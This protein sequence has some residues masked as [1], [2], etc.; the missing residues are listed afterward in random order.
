MA[1]PAPQDD[2]FIKQVLEA[3]N[4]HL[5]KE[6]RRLQSVLKEANARIAALERRAKNPAPANGEAAKPPQNGAPK[7]QP[8]ENKAF[9][10]L[11]ERL[12]GMAAQTAKINALMERAARVLGQPAKNGP[13]SEGKQG[14]KERP[15]A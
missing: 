4:Q 1:K 14:R 6:N 5:Q 9:V 7:E 12:E 8:D 15:A 11:E 13:S 10:K 3:R 2:R